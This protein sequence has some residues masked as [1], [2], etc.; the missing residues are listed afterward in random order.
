MNNRILS[1]TMLA[2]TIAIL[3]ACG[4]KTAV[5]GFEYP[6]YHPDTPWPKL[7]PTAELEQVPD[8]DVEATIEEIEA[9]KRLAN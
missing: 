8:V 2:L 6:V 7:G 5:P 1:C 9:L 4:I 3:G